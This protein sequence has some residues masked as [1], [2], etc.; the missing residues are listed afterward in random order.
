MQKSF[1]LLIL[2]VVVIVF[3]TSCKQK[4]E[5]IEDPV[6]K[7]GVNLDDWYRLSE[8]LPN[9]M[10]TLNPIVTAVT[11]DETGSEIAKVLSASLAY[12]P[13]FDEYGGFVEDLPEQ[14]FI[15][16]GIYAGTGT[17][18]GM[19]G[20]NYRVFAQVNGILGFP[21]KFVTSAQHEDILAEIFG[22]VPDYQHEDM[23][24]FE[25]ENN[26]QYN[27][28][29]NV[30]LYAKNTPLPYEP[31]LMDWSETTE[32]YTCLVV[33]VKMGDE[34]ENSFYTSD[35]RLLAR[36]EIYE[37]IALPENMGSYTYYEITLQKREGFAPVVQKVEK[38]G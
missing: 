36:W 32:T 35:G 16:T 5:Q 9:P 26:A 10:R 2:L 11:T 13:Y 1:K 19:P 38:F 37:D 23:T 18:M 22:F 33:F 7:R 6:Y 17:L 20:T 29:F 27:K 34:S 31:I 8:A 12:Y 24:K 28:D 3:S 30:Y 25:E 21:G 15:V 14:F 4:S